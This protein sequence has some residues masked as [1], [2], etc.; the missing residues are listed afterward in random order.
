MGQPPSKKGDTMEAKVKRLN[1]VLAQINDI[2][3]M[4]LADRCEVRL[5]ALVEEAKT[6]REQLN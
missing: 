4:G 3:N 1:D 2:I 6:L 5:E